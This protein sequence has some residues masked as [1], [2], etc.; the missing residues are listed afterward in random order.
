MV[1]E[2]SPQGRP[3]SLTARLPVM[4]TAHNADRN[5]YRMRTQFPARTRHDHR[6]EM[7]LIS[8]DLLD[9]V[10]ASISIV[11]ELGTLIHAAC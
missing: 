5:R 10:Q 4:K 8:S 2:V 11:V 3:G 9:D 1:E 7:S 6:F